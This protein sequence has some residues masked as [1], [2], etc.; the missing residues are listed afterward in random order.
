MEETSPLIRLKQGLSKSSKK[1]TEGFLSLILGRK[2][3]DGLV[4]VE[5]I[6]YALWVCGWL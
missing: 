2:I 6:I 1:L 5:K 3:I 4:I